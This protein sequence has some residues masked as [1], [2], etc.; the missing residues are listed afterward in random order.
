MRYTFYLLI[1][2]SGFITAAT[3][4][5]QSLQKKYVQEAT[6]ALRTI[7][8]ADTGYADLERIGNAIG[9]ARVVMLGE[10][11][12]GDAPTFLAKTRLI[13]YL[14]EKKGFNVLAFESDFFGLNEG[15]NRLPKKKDT[16][17][18]FLRSNIFPIW[19]YCDGCA[20][21][22]N[23]YIPSTFQTQHPLQIS[24]FDNQM[25]LGYSSTHLLP[26][27]DSLFSALQL[28]IWQDAVS[29]E[30]IRNAMDS[31]RFM[32]ANSKPVKTDQQQ[33]RKDLQQLKEEAAAKLPQT[34]YAFLI[35][36]NMIRQH[37]QFYLYNNESRITGSNER[38]L[39]MARNLDWLSK[40]KY[41]NEKIIVWAANAHIAPWKGD[42][43]KGKP[44]MTS[45]GTV[46]T[47]ELGH[48][49]DTYI[50]G[51]TSYKGEAGRLGYPI[52]KVQPPRKNSFETWIPDS[53]EYSFTD[54]IPFR[55]AHPEEQGFFFMKGLGH[56]GFSQNWARVY[57]GVLFI[58]QMYPCK[59]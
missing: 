30:R 44:D 43:Q 15:W 8:P 32:Y 54:F 42:P 49:D 18:R 48:Q 27:M 12:H 14:H 21:L 34:A 20:F 51:F 46:F 16:M 11:D 41:P 58:R 4:K 39:Q 35:I 28:P 59:R 2:I 53:M 17:V 55:K 56:M 25:I 52:S 23:D 7:D 45:M 36:E 10:Q 19:T 50:L 3:A 26:Y 38:D 22:F 33:F 31:V 37:E 24:G 29:R 57:S 9:A 47:R 5:G 1:A 13:R 40:V 6:A